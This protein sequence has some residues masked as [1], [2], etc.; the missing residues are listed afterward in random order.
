MIR[1]LYLATIVICALPLLPGVIGIAVPAFSW[2]PALGLDFPNLSAFSSALQWPGL[3]QSILLTLFSG[4]GSTVLATTFCFLILQANWNSSR[5]QRIEHLIAPMLAL[6]HV[7]FAI[8]FA[9]TFSPTGWLFRVA[10]TAGIDTASL[11]ALIQDPYGIGL[12][13]ALAIKETPFLLLM[14]VSVLHQI[15]FNQLQAVASGLGYSHSESWLKVILP[16]WLPKM[17]MPIY[18]VLAYGLSVVDIAMILGPSRP[19]TLAI[20]VWQWFNEPDLTQIPRAAVGAII[21]LVLSFGVLTLARLIEWLLFDVKR[22]WQYSGPSS[23]KNKIFLSGVH[24]HWPFTMV[25]VIVV[26]VL[27]I[28]SFAQRWR[29]PDLL[30]S[31]YST[32]FWQQES[33]SLIQLASN[34]I[35]L[36]LS[37]AFIAL[38]LAIGC[39]EHRQKYQ[40][41]I[42]TWLIALPMV[43]PQ[44]SILFG[45][46]V[47]TF[48]FTGQHYWF[49]VI[50]SH[51]L[52]V[53]PYLYLALDGP[54][55]TYDIRL[56]QSARSLG[57]SAWSAWWRVKRPLMMP[58]IW[59]ALAVGMSVSLAQYLPTQI[60]GA[61]RISTLTTEAVALASGQDRRV[62]AI[63]GLLQGLLP[64]VFFTLALIASRLSGN[65]SRRSQQ[66]RSTDTD[67][68]ICGKP[69]Y[70]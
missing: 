3:G 60:L 10:E 6:P 56:D 28:W 1:L 9:F 38:V 43:I 49:W 27:F 50:W 2:L 34:S 26:P 14:S 33:E 30:P 46:Q 52:F 45:I 62:S 66:Q 17:R 54:W 29:F 35:L 20:L 23:K 15:Q 32:R 39:L 16:Q 4:V 21:L 58:A 31:R 69:H 47:S 37:S 41:G 70:K 63:Y 48:L 40:R 24:L 65:Y 36:A 44:L 11:F 22:Q 5:W 12:M 59:L 7:A 51:V 57:L 19:P 8:G 42:P 55:R 13:L 53:F 64:L 18:A 61:G 67:D 25:P 68:L